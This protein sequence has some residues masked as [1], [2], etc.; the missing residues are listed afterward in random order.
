VYFWEADLR[1]VYFEGAKLCGAEFRNATL[2]SCTFTNADLTDADLSGVTIT[3]P[4]GLAK[5]Q[6]AKAKNVPSE[7]LASAS[8]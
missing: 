4:V 6:L 5:A 1:N 8:D 3:N 2:D 7:V